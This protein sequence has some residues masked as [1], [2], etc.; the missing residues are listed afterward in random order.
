MFSC[1]FLEKL[2]RKENF[3]AVQGDFGVII[4]VAGD[5]TKINH[6]KQTTVAKLPAI[7]EDVERSNGGRGRTV[8]VIFETAIFELSLVVNNGEL[9]SD[10]SHYLDHIISTFA[11]TTK[12]GT[13]NDAPKKP[14]DEEGQSVLDSMPHEL[15]PANTKSENIGIRVRLEPVKDPGL[16]RVSVPNK[17]YKFEVALKMD[18]KG[19]LVDVEPLHWSKGAIHEM[20]ENISFAGYSFEPQRDSVLT[21]RVEPD[22]GYVYVSGQG[23]LSTPKKTVITFSDSKKGLV[24]GNPVKTDSD[25]FVWSDG[26]LEK[27]Y[28]F[29]QD[30]I[31]KA[32]DTIFVKCVAMETMTLEGNS[33]TIR[34][35]G[36]E[37][38]N[39]KWRFF[40]GVSTIKEL[41]I[42]E[43]GVI[44][45]VKTITNEKTMTVGFKVGE[46][47]RK[48]SEILHELLG[49]KL[50]KASPKGDLQKVTQKPVQKVFLA[51][52]LTKGIVEMQVHGK[53]SIEALNVTLTR[54]SQEDMA[55]VIP[56]GSYFVTENKRDI[57]AYWS[58]DLVT[59]FFLGSTELSLD[60]PVVKYALKPTSP[61][62]ETEFFL[63]TP[64][65]EKIPK[66]LDLMLKEGLPNESK[67]LAVWIL[68]N[69]NLTRDEIDSFYYIR[70]SGLMFYTEEAVKAEYPV[71]AFTALNHIGFSLDMFKL[72]T[73]QVSLVHALGSQNN[74]VREFALSELVQIGALDKFFLNSKDFRA[75]LLQF[76]KHKNR[77]V[78]YRAILGLEK[79]MGHEIVQALLPLV[80]DETTIYQFPSII[81]LATT[82][83]ISGAVV[84]VLKHMRDKHE[85]E[86]ISLLQSYDYK[87]RLAGIDIFKGSQ[88]KQVNSILTKLSKEDEYKKV[89]EA[90]KEALSE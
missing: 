63:R 67:Q 17:E 43:G 82:R 59:F 61:S 79:N 24:I 10:Y 29:T 47:D 88:S 75:A 90:A 31:N 58:T 70:H 35:S 71:Y 32:L 25:G 69:P 55:V 3:L 51:E 46:G 89:R 49:E 86:L 7:E 65:T 73:E 80:S 5:V 44:V 8:K 74:T 30:D 41:N 53:N 11:V 64:P 77:S 4:D 42:K 23:K 12:S 9:F 84:R 27:E 87:E 6:V 21:F 56:V 1:V 16:L 52:A 37:D 66:L 78:R 34:S 50:S 85:D 18:E 81:G 62:E 14:G 15:L 28:A 36:V 19:N 22:K 48:S 60:V 45:A 13:S 40:S 54:K 76:I 83:T 20:A 2:P 72:Y 33:G 38:K 39:R 68:Y 57:E 26:F